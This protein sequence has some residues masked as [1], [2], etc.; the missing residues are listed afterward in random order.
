LKLPLPQPTITAPD[1]DPATP[2]HTDILR[3]Y[4]V[5]KN[6]DN[7]LVADTLA[8]LYDYTNEMMTVHNTYK[9]KDWI[10]EDFCKKESATETKCNNNLNVW[11]KHAE[12][13]FRSNGSRTNPNLQ[14]SYPVMYL[15][16]RPKD[17]GNVSG[18][19]GGFINQECKDFLKF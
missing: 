15:F 18:W 6:Y 11:L 3:F 13:L 2:I 16:N 17:I 8:R 1:S 4:V 10:F 9:E 12:N 14:L 5:H 7:L 19:R